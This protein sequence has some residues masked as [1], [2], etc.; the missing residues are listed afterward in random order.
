MADDETALLVIAPDGITA[1]FLGGSVFCLPLLAQ[2]DRAS[3]RCFYP[4]A[5]EAPEHHVW[6]KLDRRALASHQ[7]SP[8][9]I[10]DVRLVVSHRC[11]KIHRRSP[12]VIG[13][14]A[15][16]ERPLATAYVLFQLLDAV[17]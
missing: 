11:P 7:E 5:C 10:L 17:N 4:G 14:S 6:S 2:T 1:E 12:P 15:S 8:S 13:M 3:I 9:Y 16:E